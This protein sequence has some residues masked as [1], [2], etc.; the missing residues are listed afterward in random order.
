MIYLV[1]LL[2]LAVLVAG[3]V[4]VVRPRTLLDF[5]VNVVRSEYGFSFAV[6]IRFVLGAVLLLAA[7]D[8]RFPVT[9]QVL[10]VIAI[11]AAIGLLFIGKT[12]LQALGEWFAARPEGLVRVLCLVVIAFGAFLICASAPG[13]AA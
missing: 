5:V 2:G 10:G 11:V 9:F 4:G 12:R 1:S 6:G 3:V 7:S 8:S 13:G